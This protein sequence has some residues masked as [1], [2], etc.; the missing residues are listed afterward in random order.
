MSRLDNLGDI[1]D[2][3][4]GRSK[5]FTHKCKSLYLIIDQ[6][7]MDPEFHEG[8]KEGARKIFS[9][10]PE[11]GHWSALNFNKL[12]DYTHWREKNERELFEE[13]LNFNDEH[14][15]NESTYARDNLYTH[16]N[17]VK[18]LYCKGEK[19][20]ILVVTA[21]QLS[22]FAE[23]FEHLRNEAIDKDHFIGLVKNWRGKDKDVT[24]QDYGFDVIYVPIERDNVV[25]AMEDFAQSAF[26][27]KWEE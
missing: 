16:I 7:C 21:G 27:K 25:K 26:E 5:P 15:K 17:A 19:C 20:A 12:H 22:D 13:I 8:V 6:S 2:S 18:N 10:L 1:L 9:M 4:E 24:L 3:Y 14:T 11:D 23:A